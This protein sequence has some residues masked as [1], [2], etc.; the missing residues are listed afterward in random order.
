MTVGIPRLGL[1]LFLLFGDCFLMGNPAQSHHPIKH[2]GKRQ[3]AKAQMLLQ[4]EDLDFIGSMKDT[5]RGNTRILK[6][7]A[8]LLESQKLVS[9]PNLMESLGK[10]DTELLTVKPRHSRGT[11]APLGVYSVHGL[12]A[13]STSGLD[14]WSSYASALPFLLAKGPDGLLKYASIPRM[15]QDLNSLQWK[16]VEVR[17]NAWILVGEGK[18]LALTPCKATFEPTQFE[19]MGYSGA[20][21]VK[22][23][24]GNSQ[25]SRLP[26]STN[27]VIVL[28]TDG[29]GKCSGLF[30]IPVFS[31][32]VPLTGFKIGNDILLE[33]QEKAKLTANFILDPNEALYGGAQLGF[34]NVSPYTSTVRIRM[35]KD[36]VQVS[37]YTEDEFDWGKDLHEQSLVSIEVERSRLVSLPQLAS[38]FQAHQS[39]SAWAVGEDES[40][41][42]DEADRQFVAAGLPLCAYPFYADPQHPDGDDNHAAMDARRHFLADASRCKASVKWLALPR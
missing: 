41:F 13:F 1:L 19:A 18:Y 23:A 7:K 21:V 16:D 9:M 27:G 38:S 17:G 34:K 33:G 8:H 25:N 20:T 29:A 28:A 22:R 24:Y 42:R 37:M 36:Q 5:Q 40:S 14:D 31:V 26:L 30:E 35:S 15:T 4:G 39:S 10:P 12:D 32:V 11:L 2:A 6:A 3:T